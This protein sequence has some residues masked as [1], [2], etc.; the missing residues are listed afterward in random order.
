MKRGSDEWRDIWWGNRKY[1]IRALN[2]A[3]TLA[4][5]RML[6]GKKEY[7]ELAKK[8]LLD[9]AKWDPKG[10]TGYRYNDEAGMPYNYYF[11]R[12]YTFLHDTLS[13]QERETCRKVMKIR[14]DEMYRHLCPRH[15][16][17]PYSSH[18]NRAW[19]FLGEV[20]IAFLGEVEGAED[21]VWFAANV[22]FNCYPVWCDDDGGWHEGALYWRSYQDRFTW[23]ADVMRS[24]M[25]VNA[26][27][28]P[29]YSQV[30]YYAMYLMPPNKVGGGF[31]DLCARSRSSHN[32]ALLS[33]YAAQSGNGHWAWYVDKIGGPRSAGGYIGFLRGALPEV[34]PKPPADLPM[35]RLFRGTGQAYMN[36]S[37]E[38]A[39]KSVQVVFKSS[40]FGTQSHGYEANNSFLLWAYGERLLIRSGLRDS[41]G[42]EHHKK[43][44]WS[45]RSVNCITLNGGQGQGRRTAAARGRIV[46]FQT[47]PE[48]DVVVGEAGA[49]YEK[50]LKRFTRSIVFVKPDLV[51]IYDQLEAPEP[52]TFD[53]WLH[54]LEKMDDADQHRLQVRRGKVACDVDIRMPGGLKLSQTNEYDPNPRSRI[55]LREWHLT[56]STQEK[57]QAMRFVTICRPRLKEQKPF[58]PVETKPQGD[59]IWLKARL[60]Q[61]EVVILL[62][63]PGKEIVIERTGA[64]ATKKMR[65]RTGD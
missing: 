62:P 39:S 30:G 55:K 42:S 33:A 60:A 58:E 63:E 9:C 24:S 52:S 23:W 47:T 59:A 14:G 38:D 22:F 17:R 32:A 5:T 34:K 43:W 64:G 16:W 19:H 13:E 45:T 2:T 21:W 8:M 27:D 3:A 44:M 11:S 56:A 1:T 40:P 46:A 51:V 53:Y 28:K 57:K 20:G 50:P 7:G 49:A 41:Y 36:T 65:V 15:L 10:A 31:G 12:V 4:F 6:G 26:F 48:I 18:S 54:S 61:G 37:L 25:G 35:S 29:Y